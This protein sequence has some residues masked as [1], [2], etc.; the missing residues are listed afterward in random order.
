MAPLGPGGSPGTTA[1]GRL[2]AVPRALREVRPLVWAVLGLTVLAAALRFAT[3]GSQSYWFD[4]AQ[5]AHEFSLS[6]G[7]MWSF[8]VSHESNPPL[9]FVLGWLWAKPFGTSPVGLRFISALAGT[10][11][12]PVLYLAGRQLISERAGLVA[13]ALA[14]VNPF[15]IWY[16]QEAR[17]YML[18]TLVC[19]LSVL[20]FSRFLLRRSTPQLSWSPV[21]SG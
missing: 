1:A 15:M 3:L 10:G 9:Y 21:F 5:S 7:G 11:L 17:E 4:E 18:L 19:G 16:S 2:H 14:A 6:F 20:F 13:A 8:M 12:I